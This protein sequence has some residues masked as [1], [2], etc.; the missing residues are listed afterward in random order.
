MNPVSPAVAS[1]V[2]PVWR[3]LLSDLRWSRLL[4]YLGMLLFGAVLSGTM[5]GIVTDPRWIMASLPMLL[6]MAIATIAASVFASVR[7]DIADLAIDRIS[8]PDR[9]IVQAL[10]SPQQAQ[11]IATV[12]L[13]SGLVLAAALGIWPFL[14]L[15]GATIV[16]EAYSRPPLRLKRVPVLAKLLIGLNSAL[17]ALA[18][19]AIAGSPVAAFPWPWAVYLVVCVGLAANFVDF[20]DVAGDRAAGIRTLPVWWG[21]SRARAFVI[22]ATVLAYAVAGLLLGSLWLVPVNLVLLVIHVRALMRQPWSEAP[23]FRAHLLSVGSLVLALPLT[24]LPGW[25]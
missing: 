3:A 18:G 12:L 14:V 25:R 11:G 8:N 4:H 22:A 10:V 13:V 2:P 17:L 9:P 15:L 6:L 5:Q 16:Y 1:P 20:K 7:N 24:Q 23:V 21:E 19:F